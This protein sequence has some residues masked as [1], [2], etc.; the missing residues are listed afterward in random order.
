MKKFQNILFDV[1]GV[2]IDSMPIWED[3]AN[4]YLKEV[5]GIDAYPELD[6][7]CATLSLL[8][9]GAYIKEKY[10][11]IAATKEELAL[12]VAVFIQEKYWKAPAK[13]GMIETVRKLHKD[14]YHLYLATASEEDNVKGALENL[15]VWDVFDDIFTCSKIGY[16]KSYT[17]YFEEVAKKIG[18]S[19]DA[20]VMIEDS[21]HSMKTAK[22]AGLTVIGVY[23]AYSAHQTEQI[24][25][26][27]DYYMESLKELSGLMEQIE[28]VI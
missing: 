23:D 16:S 22:E 27:C 17:A 20:L 13:E 15:G 12:G 10:P 9:A 4:V 2:L 25:K 26:T 28:K 21:L 8:E 3:S 11:K 19:C 18:C 7:E 6:R 14:G 24:R 5:W 1:D